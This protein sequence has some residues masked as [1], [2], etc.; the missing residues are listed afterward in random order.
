MD[1]LELLKQ[2]AL[3]L[4]PDD[5]RDW[6]SLIDQEIRYEKFMADDRFLSGESPSREVFIDGP[7]ELAL[8]VVLLR[9]TYPADNV[10]IVEDWLFDRFEKLSKEPGWPK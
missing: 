5:G 1:E 6:E 4:L 7:V 8:N 3:K 10:F 2:Q 9:T